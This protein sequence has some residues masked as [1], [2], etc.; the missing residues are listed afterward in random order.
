[1]LHTVL[2]VVVASSIVPTESLQTLWE[3][4][5]SKHGSGGAG[6]WWGPTFARTNDGTVLLAALGKCDPPKAPHETPTWYELRRSFDGGV[7]WQAPTK[8]LYDGCTST[9]FSGSSSAKRM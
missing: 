4:R 1:M 6:N 9:V 3:Y 2:F 5:P 8:L 7:S